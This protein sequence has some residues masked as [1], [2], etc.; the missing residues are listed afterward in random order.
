MPARE[1]LVDLETEE[2]D[3]PDDWE[4]DEVRSLA[5]VGGLR[6]LCVLIDPRC[7]VWQVEY[8]TLEFGNH[9]PADLLAEHNEVQLLVRR[10]PA[11]FFQP[12]TDA[13]NALHRL[14]SRSHHL[15]ASGTSTSRVPTRP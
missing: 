4:E 13:E 8:V 1:M 14:P 11:L 12:Q 7:V 2:G 10:C 3:G 15:R 6:A 5:P 9:L